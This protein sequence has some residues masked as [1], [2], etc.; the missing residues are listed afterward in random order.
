MKTAVVLFN[1][2]GPDSLKA[3]KPFL[4]NLFN[5][6]A[7]IAL[8][9][10]IRYMLAS[11]IARKRTPKAKEIYDSIGGASPLLENTQAQ[12]EAL[13][14]KLAT[15][16]EYK[17]FV[18]MRHWKP[19]TSATVSEVK[20]YSPSRVILL[21][22]YPQYST[23]TTRSAFDAWYKEAGKQALTMPH[24]PVCCYPFDNHFIDAHVQ[25]IQPLLSDA[26][27]RGK[28]RILFSA[29]GLPK[30]IIAK[31]DPYQWQVERTVSAILRKLGTVDSVTCY[32]SRVGSLE[33]IAPSTQEEIERA[34]K[35]EVPVVLVPVSFVSE[36][37]ETLAEQDIEYKAL[38]RRSGVPHY[39][40]VPTLSVTDD[41]IET[42]AWLCEG[43]RLYPNCT[44][45]LGRI[46]PKEFKQCGYKEWGG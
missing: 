13:E 14:E 26:G 32:Q 43:T 4:F 7:I 28:P 23:T 8:P 31:G 5:D 45:A 37:V 29:H 21:P 39:E 19:F 44:N 9:Q 16:G 34:G 20:D 35:D 33:W 22:L 46:C 18:S 3:V 36:H 17:V 6:K 25:R 1:L 38:A 24:H 11:F 12:A 27:K 41:F 15:R 30:K 10:P 42:L 40:R 2:G